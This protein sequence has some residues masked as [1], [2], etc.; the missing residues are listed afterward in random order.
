[1]GSPYTAPNVLNYLISKGYLMIAKWTNGVVGSYVDVG[2]C[3]KFEM[4]PTEQSQ[5]HFSSRQGVKEQDQEIV[6][7]TGYNLNFTLDEI[8]VENLRM[9]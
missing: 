4:E 2:N 1:M 6:I 9:F 7:Q 5:E 8:S 3:P